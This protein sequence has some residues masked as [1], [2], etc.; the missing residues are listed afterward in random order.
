MKEFEKCA[1][2]EPKSEDGKK[3][4]YIYSNLGQALI[5]YVLQVLFSISFLCAYVDPG[6]LV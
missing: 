4:E 6:L 5:C 2:S 1:K 3:N